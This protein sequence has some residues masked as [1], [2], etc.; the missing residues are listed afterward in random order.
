M[1]VNIT[2]NPT[3]YPD[4]MIGVVDLVEMQSGELKSMSTSDIESMIADLQRILKDGDEVKEFS[5]DYVYSK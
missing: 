3:N 2:F 4:L 1:S 5:T